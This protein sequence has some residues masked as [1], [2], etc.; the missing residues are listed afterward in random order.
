[1]HL[2]IATE[3]EAVWFKLHLPSGITEV[4]S[5]SHLSSIAMCECIYLVLLFPI[6]R[7][8]KKE[9]ELV[10]TSDASSID[11]PFLC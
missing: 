10:T 3:D 9:T 6:L 8:R 5:V 11:T 2:H 7:K 4:A 1:M